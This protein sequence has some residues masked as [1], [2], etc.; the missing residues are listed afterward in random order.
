M[1]RRWSDGLVVAVAIGSAVVM[2]G[3]ESPGAIAAAAVFTIGFG[4]LAYLSYRFGQSWANW[5]L[6]V[7]VGVIV[8]PDL[9]G[10]A[11][12]AWHG[13]DQD[14]VRY[15]SDVLAG[16][17]GAV[18]T[19]VGL[20]WPLFIAFVWATRPKIPLALNRFD[21]S[22]MW[23]VLLTALYMFSIYL[24]SLI[25]VLDT[26]I[27]VFL[28]AAFFWSAYR[29]R[30][31][32]QPNA[33]VQG[34]SSRRLIT[35]MT[36]AVMAIAV[37]AAS[38]NWFVINLSEI[39]GSS[40]AD[41]FKTVQ[42]WFSL[43]SKVPILLVVWVMVQ[44]ARSGQVTAGLL[45]GHFVLLATTLA[46]IPLLYLARTAALGEADSFV[47]DDRQRTELLLAAAQSVF[48]VVLLAR[49][50][51]TRRAAAV[52]FGLFLVQLVISAV[53]PGGQVTLV[54]TLLAGSYIGGSLFIMLFD[55]SRLH[56][57]LDALPTE[58]IKLFRKDK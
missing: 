24:K 36:V 11:T 3:V 9:V 23:F 13:A 57:M 46:V 58:G 10:A 25:S 32:D 31:L 17:T 55:R 38:S 30:T 34:I 35:V 49:M 33:S 53:Q 29:T 44:Q 22:A 39:L 16:S 47:L 41:S 37:I 43:G 21:G 51:A 6:L 4:S 2:L 45:T 18:R 42:W 26:V 27:L 28:L 1:K 54:Q 56:V 48:L 12:L 7:L 20:L 14:F 5:A 15:R 50:V 52:L 40:D 19:I 8:L